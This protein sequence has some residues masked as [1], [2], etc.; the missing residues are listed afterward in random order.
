MTRRPL[1]QDLNKYY[2]DR[3]VIS[4]LSRFEYSTGGP[5][6]RSR[7]TTPTSI[8]TKS[9][10]DSKYGDFGNETQYHV[11]ST[12]HGYLND[13]Y[14]HYMKPS[15]G[16]FNDADNSFVPYP[17]SLSDKDSKILLPYN[18]KAALDLPSL[19]S[20]NTLH[21]DQSNDTLCSS[22]STLPSKTNKELPP[23]MATEEY[24]K[25]NEKDTESAYTPQPDLQSLSSRR[26]DLEHDLIK[27]VMNRPVASFP[28]GTM[29]GSQIYGDTHVTITANFILYV[30]EIIIAIIVVTLCSVLAQKDNKLDNSVYRYLI[31]DGIVS[32]IV[33]LLFI[34]TV[35]NFEKRNGNFYC[36][37]AAVMNF[38]SFVIAIAV[39][40]PNSNCANESIC[41]MR[42]AAAGFII[43][44]FCLW[45]S[46][47]V[48]LLTTYYISNLNL[49]QDI[50]FDY[51][52]RG[53][54]SNYNETIQ[55]R[56]VPYIEP[57]SP[58][59]NQPLREYLLNENGEMYEVQDPAQV[60][61]RSK[62]IVYV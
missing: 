59:S 49:L 30:F 13:I 44:S 50:N 40:I 61:G 8:D 33:L 21:I 58:D 24:V 14:K 56:P 39:L 57:T 42:K 28:V 47:L 48:M 60:I 29:T 34:T 53:L 31:A 15:F 1:E 6:N 46:N 55:N 26:K 43:I 32:L 35:I 7:N 18:N 25:Q 23:I 16:S 3:R 54:D 12:N 36:L 27:K 5:R 52:N 9:M 4:D 2:D 41:T 62:I 19:P 10:T 11:D 20:F 22:S 51:S 37:V 45:L 17:T 38:V